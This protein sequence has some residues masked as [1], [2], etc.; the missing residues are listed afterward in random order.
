VAVELIHG[1]TLVHDDVLDGASRGAVSDRGRR[2]GRL[3]ATS[4]GDLLFSRAFCALA[5]AGSL[6]SVRVLARASAALAQAS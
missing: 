6:E 5:A 4:T 3:A 1:A 2:R